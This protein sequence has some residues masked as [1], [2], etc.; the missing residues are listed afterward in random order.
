MIGFFSL[1]VPAGLTIYWFTSN[2][3]TLAQSLAVRKYYE[4]NP[5]Q[6]ELPDYWD[7]I[8]KVEEMSME[9]K[10]Q[11]AAAGIAVGPK[12]EELVVK[13]K[14]HT[15]VERKPLRA[16]S[17]AWKRVEEGSS[18]K[19]EIPAELQAWVSAAAAATGTLNGDA[20]DASSSSSASSSSQ[21]PQV[22]P[23][24]SS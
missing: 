22:V 5:P 2:L 16:D 15:V 4:A 24:A 6:I 21:E 10:K 14:F 7:N 18:D 17:D 13:L 3:F 12:L 20:K 9:Q 19:V 23:Q 8:D 1:Q 11:A